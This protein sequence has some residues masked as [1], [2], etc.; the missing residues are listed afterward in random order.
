MDGKCKRANGKWMENVKGEMDGKCKRA[1][2]KWMENVK[3]QMGNG[4]KM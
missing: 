3:G 2:G 1:N 4:W